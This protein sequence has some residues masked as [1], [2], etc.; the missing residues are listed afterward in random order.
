[1]VCEFC[2]QG[3]VYKVEVNITQEIIEICDECDTVWFQ[4][5]E[6]IKITNFNQYMSNKELASRWSEITI[7]EEQ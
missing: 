2:Q 7:L 4:E 6:C 5:R 3:I 1:M